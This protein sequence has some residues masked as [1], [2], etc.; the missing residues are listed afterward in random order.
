VEFRVLVG[1]DRISYGIPCVVLLLVG[2]VGINSVVNV[3]GNRLSQ[4]YSSTLQQGRY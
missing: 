4:H 2:N 3:T 1:V